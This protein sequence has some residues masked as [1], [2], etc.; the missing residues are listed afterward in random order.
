MIEMLKPNL[1]P[2]VA[3]RRGNP[4]VASR[5]RLTTSPAL[6]TDGSAM[7]EPRAECPGRGGEKTGTGCVAGTRQRFASPAA[8]GSRGAGW[9]GRCRT[10]SRPASTGNN[11]W[12]A[13]HLYRKRRLYSKR[14]T[15]FVSILSCVIVLSMMPATLLG[16]QGKVEGGEKPAK[17]KLPFQPDKNWVPLTQ[18]HEVWM[19][20]ES[21]RILVGGQ[22]CLNNG[23]LE[24]FACPKGT[25]EHEAIVAV[26]TPARYVHAALVALGAEPGPP[27]QF[28]PDYKPAQGT[29]IEV[30]V[31]W[32]D[33]QGKEHSVPAQQ[34][35]KNT[36]TDQVLQYPWVFAGSGFWTDEETGERFYYAD[37]GEFICVSNFSTAMLDLPIRSTEANS[38]LLFSA[39][40]ERIPPLGTRVFLQLTP[41]LKDKQ[42]TEPSPANAQQADGKDENAQEEDGK[43]EDGKEANTRAGKQTDPKDE[44]TG[45]AGKAPPNTDSPPPSNAKPREKAPEQTAR[46][47]RDKRQDKRQTP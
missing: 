21:K 23:M 2:Q 11:A 34:W 24:M 38:A 3:V 39:F 14:R 46:N 9:L 30:K 10:T 42:P 36:K 20:L 19:N 35:I 18:D 29:E 15:T 6:P 37:G 12:H 47:K 27:V 31:I 17:P 8:V 25:K 32:E 44:T 13:D 43:E 33:Q 41:K 5:G 45:K 4:A 26:N 7:S 22:V 1:T 28:R 40:T 16:R